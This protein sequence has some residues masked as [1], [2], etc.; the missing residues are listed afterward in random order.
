MLIYCE[1]LKWVT[2]KDIYFLNQLSLFETYKLL[3]TAISLNVIIAC[4][5]RKGLL[6]ISPMPRHPQRKRQNI[7]AHLTFTA[8]F[9]CI[10]WRN[11]FNGTVNF[12]EAKIK[13]FKDGL[14]INTDLLASVKNSYNKCPVITFKLNSEII[15]EQNIKKSILQLH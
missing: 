12:S 5:V 14:G 3:K 9:V 8:P 15:V 2:F 10:T 11:L 7:Q 4:F 1:L 6:S 13:I